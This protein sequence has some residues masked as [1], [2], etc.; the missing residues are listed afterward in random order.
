MVYFFCKLTNILKSKKKKKK[1]G[2]GNPDCAFAV[3]V[4]TCSL[5]TTTCLSY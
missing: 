3:L 1:G 5:H 2:G 4:A